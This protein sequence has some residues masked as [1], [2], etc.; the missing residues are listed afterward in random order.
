MK[1]LFIKDWRLLMQQKTFFLIVAG[2]SVFLML[3]GQDLLF[4]VSYSSF[5]TVSMAVGTISYDDTGN[6]LAYIFTWP[7]SRKQYVL[8]KYLL[9]G[10]TAGAVWVLAVAAG[11]VVF[12]M[13]PDAGAG[14]WEWILQSLMILVI[15]AITLAV[16]I[17]IKIK[18][19]AEKGR[20]VT[21][22]VIFAMFGAVGL[23]SALG[24]DTLQQLGTAVDALAQLPPWAW[25]AFTAVF[26]AAL[27][28]GSV[29]I[30]IRIV[31]KK[32]L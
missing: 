15:M 29:C 20:I 21:F 5:L 11:A 9:A 13:G 23:V 30:S 25:A 18:F 26:A 10:C 31:E 6:G 16:M 24:G 28:I 8:E 17:P 3:T 19:G 2:I 12:G 27:L 22:L 32:E 4:M 7:A 14:L 1:G